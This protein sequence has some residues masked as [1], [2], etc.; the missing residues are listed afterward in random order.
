VRPLMLTRYIEPARCFTYTKVKSDL[1]ST[2][3][4]APRTNQHYGYSTQQKHF[5]VSRS[6]YFKFFIFTTIFSSAASNFYSDGI[7]VPIIN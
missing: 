6:S 2:S 1:E 4:V 7:V 3:S 5:F